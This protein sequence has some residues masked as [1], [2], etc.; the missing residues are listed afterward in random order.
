VRFHVDGGAGAIAVI[1]AAGVGANVIIPE[2]QPLRVRLPL[3]CA[4]W[5]QYTAGNAQWIDISEEEKFLFCECTQAARTH[6]ADQREMP[7]HSNRCQ[8]KPYPAPVRGGGTQV[9]HGFLYSTSGDNL[10]EMIAFGRIAGE[11]AVAEKPRK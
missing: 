1:T 2:K 3:V 9:H 10:A 8:W 11:N 7:K 4:A 6:R 5:G